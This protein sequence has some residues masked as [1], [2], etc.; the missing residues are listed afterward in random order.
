LFADAQAPRDAAHGLLTSLVGSPVGGLLATVVLVSAFG[1][2]DGVL[3]VWWPGASPFAVQVVVAWLVYGF[4]D[5]WKHRAYHSVDAL[6]WLH[7]IHHDVTQMHV[8]KGSRLHLLEGTVR[9]AFVM[10]PLLVL[11]V[12]GEVLVWPTTIDSFLGNLNHSNLDQ[13]FARFVHWLVP[14]VDLHHIHHAVDRSLHDTNLGVPILDLAFG[15]YTAPQSA[16]RP[17]VGIANSPVPATLVG[18][19]AFPFRQWRAAL[20][21]AP[22]E[23]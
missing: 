11:G 1:S 9:A 13:R 20:Q 17:T 19:L 6:W 12:P 4:G 5:Y 7:A 16:P 18:Q 2:R 21:P 14:T 23:R 3:A 22:A 10:L 8:L 15:T